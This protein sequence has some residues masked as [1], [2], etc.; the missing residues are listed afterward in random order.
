LEREQSKQHSTHIT[1]AASLPEHLSN[2]LTTQFQVL[3]KPSKTCEV[4]RF[5]RIS[6]NLISYLRDIVSSNSF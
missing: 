3:Y 1:L 2:R 5:P 4:L 6:S